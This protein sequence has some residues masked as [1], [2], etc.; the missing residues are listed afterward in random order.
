MGW[1]RQ[2]PFTVEP[3]VPPSSGAWLLSGVLAVITAVLLFILHASG[4][5]SVLSVVNIWLFSL[6]PV[7]LWLIIFSIRGYFY[8]RDLD[9]Y[10]FLQHEAQHAQQQWTAWAER[11]LAVMASCVMLPD[12][13]SAALLQQNAKG[14]TQYRDLVRRIDYLPPDKPV[15]STAMTSLLAGVEAA[16]LALPAELPLQVTVLAD[17][18]ET[19]RQNLHAQFADG[20]QAMFPARPGPSSL[21][22][23]DKLSFHTIDERIK[24][25]EE[26]VQ[27]VLVV[28]MQGNE[29]YSDGLAALLFTSD[30]V[31][32]KYSLS[33]PTRLLRPMQWDVAHVAQEL[34]LFL[35]TQT[36]A[37]RTVGI[38]GDAQKWTESSSEL[39]STGNAQGTPWGPDDIRTIETFCGIQGPFSPWMTAALAADFVRIGR[40]SWLALSTSDSEHF[41]C[42]ITSGS[43]D[44]P[45]K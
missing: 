43:G 2:K 44:E 19:S 14:L 26:T 41:I 16:V 33:H 30:D 3:P 11:Y 13:I 9:R 6:T 45:A 22:I 28:Q 40:Q 25:P 38:L 20:W 36:Q 17:V 35:T 1:E 24:Q 5:L 39:L 7:L 37:L 15:F 18:P 4:R 8:G 10:Q 42:T 34:E 12:H 29:S 31:A 32:H 21:T 27:L 23:A